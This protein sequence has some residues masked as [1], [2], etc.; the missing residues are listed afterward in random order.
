MKKAEKVVQRVAAFARVSTDH[1]DQESS[2]AAQTDYYRKKILQHAEWQVAGAFVD[3]GIS[4]LSTNRREGFNRVIDTCLNGDIDLVLP[5]SISRF[6]WNTVDTGTIIRRLKEKGIGVYF[7]KENIFT[8]DPKG[9][10]LLTIMSS[11]AQ[12]ES[13]LISENVKWGQRKR[14][15]DG[16]M[17]LAYSRF[18][19]YDNGEEKYTMVVN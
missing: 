2:L 19:G 4:G 9:E 12:E 3:D 7:E 18:L 6:A 13:R 15:A 10:F 5:K 1:E 16:K 11:L 8:P 14:F 17:S